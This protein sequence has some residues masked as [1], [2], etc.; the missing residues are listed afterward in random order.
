MRSRFIGS[1]IYRRSIY[2][3]RHLLPIP[4]V[5]TCI[6]FCRALGWLPPEGQPGDA[7]IDSSPA[8]PTELA[9]FHEPAYIAAVRRAEAEQAL[10]V[11]DRESV[12]TEEQPAELQ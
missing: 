11:E 8:T 3:G 9:R 1:E 10:P 4:R 7:Y 12:R 5:S 2:G 6:D